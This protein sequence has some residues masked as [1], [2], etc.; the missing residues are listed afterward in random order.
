MRLPATC[1]TPFSIGGE[2]I[3]RTIR[4]RS[5]I[6]IFSADVKDIKT[7][8]TACSRNRA[9]TFL[10]VR[11]RMIS[12]MK[13]PLP[14]LLIFWAA[15]LGC[16]QP[17]GLTNRV[18][19]TTLRMPLASTPG[20]NYR[21]PPDNP[22]VGATNFNGG[23]IDPNNVRTEFYAVG[24]RNPWRYSFDPVSGLLWLADVGQNAREE[25]DIIVKGGNYG[26]A[27]REGTMAGPKS[28]PPPGFTSIDPI[29][30]YGRTL[31]NS[32]TGGFVYRGSRFPELYGAY[33]FGD[34]GSG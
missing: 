22:F 5:S 1:T 4:A 21:I 19:N 20:I 14:A 13:I 9:L 29:Y 12:T 25:I 26:W 33:I 3:G 32:V 2:L 27:Y 31:G 23:A 24:L 11:F 15:S 6:F 18:A 7:F 8:K 28:P 34:Y 10:M 30:D 16:A 17:F